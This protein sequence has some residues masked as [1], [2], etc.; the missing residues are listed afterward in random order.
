MLRQ[1]QLK[2]DALGAATSGEA[3]VR[4][5]E[6]SSGIVLSLGRDGGAAVEH[7]QMASVK[8]KRVRYFLSSRLVA[9]G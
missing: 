9:L 8:K 2:P 1:S 4:R 5:V 3:V 7:M 6:L